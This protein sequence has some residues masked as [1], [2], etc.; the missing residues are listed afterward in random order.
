MPRS[1]SN[2]V[3]ASLSTNDFDLRAFVFHAWRPAARRD[4]GPLRQA[5]P[6]SNFRL[7]HLSVLGGLAPRLSNAAVTC[8]KDASRK[9]GL[10]QDAPRQV[11]VCTKR[12]E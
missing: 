5:I 10:T 3:L 7:R 12:D 11:I 4:C 6:G 8:D 2:R 1:S 9:I